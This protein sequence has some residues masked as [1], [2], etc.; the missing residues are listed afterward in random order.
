MP[1]Y[2][3]SLN[4]KVDRLTLI[5]SSSSSAL[6]IVDTLK[7]DQHNNWIEQLQRLLRQSVEA[8][9]SHRPWMQNL[10][11]VWLQIFWRL[12]N[13]RSEK[14]KYLSKIFQAEQSQA[15]SVPLWICSKFK[16]NT[17]PNMRYVMPWHPSLPVNMVGY[18]ISKCTAIHIRRGS[19][20]SASG[21]TKM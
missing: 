3:Y 14:K 7:Q 18:E 19:I 10:K 6:P 13:L 1:Y 12:M 8:I 15:P 21:Q 5:Q 2:Y 11:R 17:L 20:T 4:F 16:L 9:Y